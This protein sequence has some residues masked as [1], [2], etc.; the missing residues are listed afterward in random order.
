MTKLN[1]EK[2]VNQWY[3][4]KVQNNREKSVS[5]R[6]KLEMKR[7]YNEDVN[8]MIPTQNTIKFKDGKKVEKSKL[9]I[10]GYIFA[11]TYSV[12]KLNHVIK[13]VTGA[14]NLLKDTSGMPIPLRQSEVDK[15]LGVQDSVSNIKDLYHEG[16]TVLI[17]NGPFTNFKGTI[18]SIDFDKEKVKVEVPIFGRK[19][20]V[21]L[22]MVDI[23]AYNE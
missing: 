11:E 19:N 15:M 22:F 1:K 5:D 23:S 20:I 9:L 17:L 18:D 8:I 2:K 12:D 14:T 6:I 7:D 3:T 4:I 10:P 13:S 21:E 16:E